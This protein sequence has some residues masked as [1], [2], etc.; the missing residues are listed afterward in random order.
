MAAVLDGGGGGDAPERGT[1]RHNLDLR[2]LTI[3]PRTTSYS[4]RQQ[5]VANSHHFLLIVVLISSS[6]YFSRCFR[7]WEQRQQRKEADAAS[8]QSI[9]TPS[10]SSSDAST[11]GDAALSGSRRVHVHS[12]EALSH[13]RLFFAF[14]YG[15][16]LELD[17]TTAHPLLRLADFYGV[18][19]LMAQCL[20]FLERV[21]HPQPTR[22]F[23]LFDSNGDLPVQPPPQE[24]PIQLCTEVLARSF[25]E[26]SAHAAFRNKCPEELLAAVLERDD[27][28]VDKES[29]VLHAIV[30]W[31]EAD[32]PRR[33]SSLDRLL[34][35]VRWPLMDAAFLADVEDA[36][37]VLCSHPTSAATLRGFLLEAFKF[38]AASGER[39]TR[40]VELAK[41]SDEA[42]AD[43]A[44]HAQHGAI[45]GRGKFC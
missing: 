21:L 11:T 42:H 8:V 37:A 23:T 17:L 15:V 12:D 35:L 14:L 20:R 25:A 22:C 3:P 39:R 31:A 6:T 7:A 19:A 10:S 33:A 44:S 24:R 26:A 9:A 2:S 43:A 29:E 16:E 28:S 34:G 38:Q 4:T 30:V 1:C 18:D 36:Y 13:L 45:A 41:D 40:L 32:L 5:L 27:L